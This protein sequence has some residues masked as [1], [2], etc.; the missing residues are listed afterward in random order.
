MIFIILIH[1]YYPDTLPDTVLAYTEFRHSMP[2]GAQL[3]FAEQIIQIL[4]N[5][6]T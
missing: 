5:L 2:L 3:V 6:S 1:V 4:C